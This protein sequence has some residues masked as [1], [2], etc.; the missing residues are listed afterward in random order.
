MKHGALTGK[1][2][3]FLAICLYFSLSSVLLSCASMGGEKNNTE[4]LGTSVENFNSAIRWE[5]YR[6]ASALLSPAQRDGFWDLVDKMQKHIR[7]MDFQ[8]RDVTLDYSKLSGNAVLKY[9]YYSLTD[10]YVQ[11]KTVHQKLRYLE[12]EKAWQITRHDL[13]LLVQDKE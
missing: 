3:R 2:A 9:S 13:E 7:I 10:P 12:K 6:G 5:E 11:T 8:I 1:F 4:T